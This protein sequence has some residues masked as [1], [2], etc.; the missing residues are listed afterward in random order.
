MDRLDAMRTLVAAVDAGS[1]SAASRVL[2]MP[3]ATV[4]RKVAEL[5][6]HLGTQ[7]L[8]RTSRRLL[9][10]EAGHSY[11]AA[12]RRILDDVDEAE[13]QAT[14]EYRAPR[15]Q[16]TIAAPVMFGRLH[17]QPVVLDFLAA[18]PE[19][20]VRL[21]LADQVA[22]LFDEH[23]DVAVRIGRLADSSMIG[24][25]LGEIRWVTCAS[26]DYLA[27]R[28]VPAEPEALVAHDC[29][30]FHG[31]ALFDTAWNYVRDGAA[32]S[33]P[34]TPRLIANAADAVIAAAIAGRGIARILSYQARS[35]IGD[36]RLMA[37]LEDFE[38]AALPVHLLHAGQAHLPIKLRAFLDF[39]RPRLK[40][41]I[42]DG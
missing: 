40:A 36:G 17:V 8:M 42:P 28:G 30:H 31:G 24:L 1:L 26:P 18:Y 10:T 6:A 20:N 14:G 5:E 3:L 7:L 33:V 23:V 37:I 29:V 2:R 13:R 35:P 15:G 19:I 41:S 11:L 12:A 4:S 22:N 27:R 9:P 25:K 34:V 32:L 39:A 38:P 16:L 21:V